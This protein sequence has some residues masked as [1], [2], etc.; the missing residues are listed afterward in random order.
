MVFKLFDEFIKG[1]DYYL[2]LHGDL[3]EKV[4]PFVY[5]HQSRNE[6]VNQRSKELAENYGTENILFTT[7][8]G[9]AYPDQGFTFSYAAENGIPAIQTKQG[10]I[11]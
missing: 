1:S 3:V 9:V 2:D 6:A 7:L 5:V 4:I 8:N 11:G 10:G